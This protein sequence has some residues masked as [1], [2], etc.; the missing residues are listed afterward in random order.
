[1]EITPEI[2]I[3]GISLGAIVPTLIYHAK[4]VNQAKDATYATVMNQT[5]R[6]LYELYRNEEKL[7]TKHECEI[8]VVR[9]LDCLAIVTNLYN[10][11]KISKD[12]LQFMKYDITVG[13][14]LLKW[15]DEH[16]LGE[17]YESNA[18]EIW[19]NLTVY[20]KKY[21]IKPASDDLL[22]TPLKNFKDLP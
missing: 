8:H 11:K 22:P 4:Q 2:I 15:F 3:A 1:L 7:K 14:R 19:S 10:R 13:Y 20:I 5:M 9:L 6:D 16:N 17:K 18:N 12:L 21:S